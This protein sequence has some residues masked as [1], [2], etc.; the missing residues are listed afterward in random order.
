MQGFLLVSEGSQHLG[1]ATNTGNF[2]N[3]I[4]KKAIVF[5]HAR[6]DSVLLRGQQGRGRWV[7]ECMR[8]WSGQ[9]GPGGP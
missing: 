9:P 3:Q 2:E 4:K 1:N 7:A 6:G 5:K 8:G